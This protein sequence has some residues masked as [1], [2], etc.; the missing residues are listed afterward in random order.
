MPSIKVAFKYVLRGFEQCGPAGFNSVAG[1]A[2]AFKIGY[3]AL[4]QR[5]YD[6]VGKPAAARKYA[7][8]IRGVVENIFRQFRKLQIAAVKQCL[9]LSKVRRCPHTFSAP[10]GGTPLFSQYT[11]L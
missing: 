4:L 9:K 3:A 8:V 6:G 11:D 1:D 2:L 7:A 5:L 10:R